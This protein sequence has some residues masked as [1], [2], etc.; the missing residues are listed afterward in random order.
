[1]LLVFTA[2]V[3]LFVK[4]VSGNDG[5]WNTEEKDVVGRDGPCNIE[6]HDANHLT[7]KE[8]LKRYYTFSN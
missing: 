3:L 6:R 8:F 7:E 1:M 2:Y 4:S 5:G